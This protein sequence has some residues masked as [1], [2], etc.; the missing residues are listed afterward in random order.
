MLDKPEAVAT[1]SQAAPQRAS[2]SG[3]L[4]ER[5][6]EI[7][8]YTDKLFSFT[9]TRSPSFRFHSGQFTMIGLEVEGR[10]LLRAYSMASAVY[11]DHLEFF[12]IKVPS[13]P[14]TSR[15]QHIKPGDEL[16]VGPKPTGTLL[17]GNLKPAKRLYLLATGTGFAPFASIL[18]DPETYEQF[19][20][21]IAVEGCRLVSEIEFATQVVVGVRSHELLGELATQQLRYHAT[22]TREPFHNKGRIPDIITSGELFHTL[23]LPDLDVAN[24]RIMMCGNPQMLAD[25]RKILIARNF[26][27][28]NSGRPGDFVIEKAFVER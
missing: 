23:E 12:S 26:H 10:P 22:V 7:Q 21:V 20:T 19:E 4:R 27:E 2:Q 28:G 17:L 13:G 3:L 5:V 18:R 14:L 24:D 9:T 15:L 6:L 16:L 8:H 11:D 25:M 1:T